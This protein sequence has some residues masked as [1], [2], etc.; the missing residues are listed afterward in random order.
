MTVGT[1]KKL[2]RQEAYRARA[3]AAR[4]LGRVLTVA[5]LM[6]MSAAAWSEPKIK[7]QLET[8]L[9][10]YGPI[11]ADWVDGAT[12][13]RTAQL[14]PQATLDPSAITPQVKVNRP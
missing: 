13:D 7:A 8:G 6:T 11:V 9:E 12:A 3:G 14:D 1:E 10:V 2:R 4:L 5:L